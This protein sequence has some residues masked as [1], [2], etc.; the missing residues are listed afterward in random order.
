MT[1]TR[2][3]KKLGMAF[4]LLGGV[5]WGLSGVFGQYLFMHNELNA[6]WLVSVRLVTSGVLL[7]TPVII[8]EKKKAVEIWKHK[9]NYMSMIVFSMFG[10][11]M[12]Q[13]SYYSAVEMSNAGTATVVQYTAPAMIMTYFAFKR[14]KLPSKAQTIAL[15]LAMIGVYVLATGGKFS[16]LNISTTALIWG[17]ISAVMM[18]VFNIAPEKLMKKYGTSCVTGWGMFV[19]GIIMCIIVKPWNVIGVWDYKAYIALGVV[20]IVGTVLSFFFYLE[21][22][23][24]AGAEIASLL[25]SVEPLTA[26]IAT[27]IIVNIAFTMWEIAGMIS[28]IAAVLILA[29]HKSE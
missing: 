24:Y 9:E 13:L 8:K 7:L 3:H 12:C 16:S 25:A 28:I 4:A 14:K 21:G 11:G 26:T 29:K 20:I 10:M 15:I 27:V 18:A 22:V 6:K 17:L 1:E 2:N 19:A 23:K 5:F